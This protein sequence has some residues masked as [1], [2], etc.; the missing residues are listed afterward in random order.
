MIGDNCFGNVRVFELDGLGEMESVVIGQD[1]FTNTK[2]ADYVW[3]EI[4][5][6][7]SFRIQNCPK[8]KSIQI[9][10]WSF[11]DYHM[12]SLTGLIE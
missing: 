8:L 2:Y 10:D 4:P 1:S 11:A 5:A 7:G 3:N 9:G 12:L 6:E